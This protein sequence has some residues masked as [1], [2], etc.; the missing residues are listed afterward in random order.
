M[1]HTTTRHKALL[2][3][4][5]NLGLVLIGKCHLPSAHVAHPETIDYKLYIAVQF[6]SKL[7]D[8]HTKGLNIWHNICHVSFQE[9]EVNRFRHI[10][11]AELSVWYSNN[12]ISFLNKQYYHMTILNENIRKQTQ[13][14]IYHILFYHR[15]KFI[16]CH[17]N[18]YLLNVRSL[19][20]RRKRSKTKVM[21]WTQYN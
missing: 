2:I 21:P 10:G 9:N 12:K 6:C 5:V 3:Q 20:F 18:I 15:S 16:F 1:G 8:E 7:S 17:S 11:T 19:I 13:I 14:K 4:L